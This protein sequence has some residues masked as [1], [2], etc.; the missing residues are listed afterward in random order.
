M[1]PMLFLPVSIP[2][3]IAAVQATAQ[4]IDGKSLR[5]IADYLVF[6]GI[7]DVVFLVLVLMVFNYI[8]EE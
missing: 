4:L 8:A 3:T 5:D 2:L 1:L 7:F 6:I